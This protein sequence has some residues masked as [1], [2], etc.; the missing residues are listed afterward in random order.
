MIASAG[1]QEIE[2]TADIAL[3]VWAPSIPELLAQAAK[4]M[5]ALCGVQSKK[6]SRRQRTFQISFSDY[7]N[8]LVNFLSELLYYVERDKL[9][10]DR[11]QITLHNHQLKVIATGYPI[12]SIQKMI[13]AVTYHQL[14][15]KTTEDGFTAQIVFDV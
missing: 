3:R 4:G 7:E 12:Q 10:L 6:Q 1:Y 8:L 15:V 14:E 2:H 5:F 11:F 13:K 9:V